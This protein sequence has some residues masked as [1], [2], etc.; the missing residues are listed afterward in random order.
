MFYDWIALLNIVSFPSFFFKCNVSY[1]HFYI[2]RGKRNIFPK[3]TKCIK[4]PQNE[5]SWDK[6]FASK[7]VHQFASYFVIWTNNHLLTVETNL[8]PFYKNRNLKVLFDNAFDHWSLMHWFASLKLLQ[9]DICKKKEFFC[10]FK[11]IW[12]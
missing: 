12:W 9:I 2:R 4:I 6:S 5:S 3:G 8:M 10:I 11:N 7:F 1:K